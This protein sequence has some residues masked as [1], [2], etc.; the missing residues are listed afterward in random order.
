MSTAIQSKSRE[1]KTRSALTALRNDGFIPSVVY[2]YNTESTP[3]A[4]K[5]SDLLK[6]LREVGRNGVLKL[7]VDGKQLNVVLNDFQEDA[8]IGDIRHADFL[9]IDMAEELEVD[10]TVH[11]VGNSVGEK[12]GG[13]V[14]QPNREVTIKVK[15]SDIPESFEVDISE[16]Q[17]GDTIT[18]AD[19]RAKSKFE[20]LSDDDYALVLIS[21]P[22]T[23][24]EMEELEADAG[25]ANA[26][27][28]V[29]G[30][31]EEE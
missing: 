13:V 15:P 3:I 28:E 29:I 16:M 12:E 24:A 25:A 27:P 8:L 6:T 19:V 1:V 22:R 26:E 21:A 20:I 30:G 14:Q 2:G 4:V 7:E 11:L 18:V 23:E 5:E 10:V 17:I 31:K 9:A